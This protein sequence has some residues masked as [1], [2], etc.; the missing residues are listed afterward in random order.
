MRLVPVDLNPEDPMPPPVRLRYLPQDGF[1]L[2]RSC[3]DENDR[4][5][6]PGDSF[7]AIGGRLEEDLPLVLG[8]QAPA[9]LHSVG[10]IPSSPGLLPPVS[11]RVPGRAVR[12][13][14]FLSSDPV[15]GSDPTRVRVVLCDELV[16]PIHPLLATDWPRIG[17]AAYHATTHEDGLRKEA[18]PQVDRYFAPSPQVEEAASRTLSRWRHG[19]KSR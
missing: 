8:R 15:R 7:A 9:A 3:T 4:P 16:G 13:W 6:G 1:R 14:D 5:P 12:V 10:H 19:F 11:R 18:N 2:V 17:P